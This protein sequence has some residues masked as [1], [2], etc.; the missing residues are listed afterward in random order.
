MILI[1]PIHTTADH[2]GVAQDAR[3][4]MEDQEAHHMEDHGVRPLMDRHRM[5]VQEAIHPTVVGG[6]AGAVTKKTIT[7]ILILH[8]AFKLQ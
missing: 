2:H 5:E 3:H 1:R 8:E 7:K 4:T 6:D